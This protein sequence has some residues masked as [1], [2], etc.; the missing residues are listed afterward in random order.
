MSTAV[1]RKLMKSKLV[2]YGLSVI[3]LLL[4]LFT[5]LPQYRT[6]FWVQKMM[7]LSTTEPPKPST[8]PNLTRQVSIRFFTQFEF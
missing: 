5:T 4:A 6:T 2:C 7:H 3:V 8:T 1:Y